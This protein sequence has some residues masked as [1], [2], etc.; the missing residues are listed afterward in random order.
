LIIPCEIAVKSLVPSLKALI[1]KELVEKYGLKQDEV[2]EVLGISQSA[3]SK[4]T[5]KVRGYVINATQVK[6]VD[7]LVQ[8]ITL[9]VINGEYSKREFLRLFCRMCTLVRENGLMCELCRK[10]DRKLQLEKCDF[11]SEKC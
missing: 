3:V 8:K 10:S 11:C 6:E 2:A 4:Y 1:V 5:R 7:F 9:R